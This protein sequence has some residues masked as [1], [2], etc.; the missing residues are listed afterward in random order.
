MFMDGHHVVRRTDSYWAGISTDLTIEQELM[1][2]V[3]KTGGLTRGRGITELQRAKWLLITPACA[4]YKL[5]IHSLASMSFETSKQHKTSRNSLIK[6][7][8]EDAIK[9]V[10]FLIDRK[11]FEHRDY[12][13]NLETGEVADSSVNVFDAKKI[14]LFI[15]RHQVD[16]SFSGFDRPIFLENKII[17]L[18]LNLPDRPF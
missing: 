18:F 11:P 3:K 7:N 9:L 6:R 15:R 2:S 13:M 12:L 1:S 10:K 16:L 14:G 5:A 8:Y 4:E 17:I